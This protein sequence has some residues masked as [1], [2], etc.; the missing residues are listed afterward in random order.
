MLFDSEVKAGKNCG[1]GGPL[2]I[3]LHSIS[4]LTATHKQK[5]FCESF[6]IQAEI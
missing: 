2:L 1:M 6:G 3:S 5:Y 4:N